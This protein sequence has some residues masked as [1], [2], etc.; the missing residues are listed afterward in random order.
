M[1]SLPHAN[2][3]NPLAEIQKAVSK[4]KP[5]PET[6]TDL[7]FVL[8]DTG[9]PVPQSTSIMKLMPRIPLTP[10]THA[11]STPSTTTPIDIPSVTSDSAYGAT[12]NIT[13]D[14]TSNIAS[15]ITSSTLP[16]ALPN[17]TIPNTIIQK[18]S[19][20][21]MYDDNTYDNMYD[22]NTTYQKLIQDLLLEIDRIEHGLALAHKLPYDTDLISTYENNLR[23]ITEIST[24]LLQSYVPKCKKK[25][26]YFRQQLEQYLS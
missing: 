6:N 26:N 19:Q 7:M 13:S 3:K 4:K 23:E 10:L 17:D 15:N 8:E 5:S 20:Y 18:F 9:S 1:E 21:N 24:I 12:S 25:C 22:N 14:I 2:I 11:S 16:N